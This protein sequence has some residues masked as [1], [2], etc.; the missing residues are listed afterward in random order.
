[1]TDVQSETGA[2]PSE[3]TAAGIT[4]TR[5]VVLL[6][7]GALGATAGLAACNSDADTVASGPLPAGSPVPSSPGS[8]GAGAT[9][10]AA[11]DVPSG[12]GV[13]KGDYVITQ[14][15]D[16]VFKAFSKVCPHKGCDVAKVSGG[17]I[18]CPCHNSRFSIEDG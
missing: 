6:G 12:G 14:P 17:L 15:S 5:R 2:A 8:D 11:N 7:A 16:G 3:N 10:V 1:M 4:S 13:I 18:I 9:L